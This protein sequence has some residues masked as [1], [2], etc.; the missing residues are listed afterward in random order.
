MKNKEEI[1]ICSCHSTDHQLIFLYEEDITES[2]KIDPICYAHVLL[3]R[4][5]FWNRLKYGIKYIFG[6]RCRYGAFDEFIF[7]PEDAYKIQRLANYLKSELE[8][9]SKD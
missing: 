4:R 6:Y 8:N 1:L 5:S 7:K 2:G 3:N 9:A